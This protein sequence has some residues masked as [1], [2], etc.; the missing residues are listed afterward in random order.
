MRSLG[1]DFGERRVGIAVS[2]P[3]GTLASPVGVITRRAGKRPP[4]AAMADAAREQEVGQI[5]MGLPLMLNGEEDA[6]CAEVRRVGDLLAERTGLPVHYVD[7]RF[8]SSE[9]ERR[10]R[11]S[12]L[13]RGERERKD[14]VDAGAATVILQAFLNGVPSR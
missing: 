5:V 13:P 12:G 3:T 2:D 10:I 8:S 4:V 1:I 14:R 9:A 7:E 11:S 6:W